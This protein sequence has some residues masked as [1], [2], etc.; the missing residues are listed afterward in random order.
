MANEK[1]HSRKMPMQ[2][3]ASQGQM[4]IRAT[5]FSKLS[6]LPREKKEKGKA[7]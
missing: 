3:E 6:K 2:I 1:H 5:S 7:K 4:R